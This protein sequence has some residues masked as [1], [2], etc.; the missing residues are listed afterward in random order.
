MSSQNTLKVISLLITASL[1]SASYASGFSIIEQSVTGLGSA[2]A[3]SAAAAED[4][5]TIYFNPAGLTELNSPEVDIALH[6]IAPQ[7]DFSDSGSSSPFGTELT[8][9]TSGDAAKNAVVPNFYY[10][11]P[12]NDSTVLG[13]GITAPFGLVTEYDDTWKGRYHAVKSDMKTININPTLAFKVNNKLSIGAGINLQKIE[14]ELTQMADLAAASAKAQGAPLSTVAA[15]SQTSD[16]KVKIEA[17]D[18]SWGYNLGLTY[19][20]TEATRFGLAYRS[21]ISHTAKGQG[22]ITH[23]ATGTQVANGSIQGKISVPESLSLAI[24]HDINQKW[25]VLAD[26]SWT[27]WSR[28]KELTVTS[29]GSFPNS[30][31]PENWS[32]TMRYGLGLTYKYNEK[33]DFRTGIAYDESPVSNEYRTPRVP[34]ED[35]QWL[36]FG[37]SY[38]YSDNIIL[39]AAYTHI[40]LDDPSINDTDSNGYS[41]EGSY[42]VEIDILAVQIRWLI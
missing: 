37:T 17:D 3:G 30:S 39:D 2:F 36:S 33:W 4:A 31:Q 29:T 12:I 32:N 9:G 13:L 20:A 19:Q 11:Q 21:K 38:H 10:S 23:Q 6:Y 28:F 26:A 16:G 25:T 35:R 5:S 27:R 8:G 34:G 14:I 7:T 15:V 42:E 41:L 24:H 1:S 18:W 40:F 22:T